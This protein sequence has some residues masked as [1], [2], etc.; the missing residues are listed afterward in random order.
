MNTASP[1]GRELSPPLPDLLYEFAL[2]GADDE[3]GDHKGPVWVALLRDGAEIRRRVVEEI[4]SGDSAARD[5]VDPDDWAA[6]RDAFGVIIR[7]DNRRNDVTARAFA[8]EEECL[9]EWEAVRA[10]LEASPPPVEAPDMGDATE[11][12][13]SGPLPPRDGYNRE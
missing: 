7:R 13:S 12:P 1:V 11:G 6:L 4:E 2:D 9:A 10:D 5:S 3:G 8:D